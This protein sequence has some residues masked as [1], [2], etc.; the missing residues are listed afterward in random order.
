MVSEAHADQGQMGFVIPREVTE[1]R[2]PEPSN[3]NVQIRRRLG[4]RF[5]VVRFSG[6]T[7]SKWVQPAE[8]IFRKTR[9]EFTVTLGKGGNFLVILKRTDSR[10]GAKIAEDE[11]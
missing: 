8:C 6:Q 1:Q 4:G 3:G 7:N 5:A 10:Q 2:V 9:L 11:R